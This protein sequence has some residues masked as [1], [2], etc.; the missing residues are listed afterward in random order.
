M[1]WSLATVPRDP[2]P[3]QT[4]MISRMRQVRQSEGTIYPEIHPPGTKVLMRV[5]GGDL[6]SF[7][8]AVVYLSS[9]FVVGSVAWVPMAYAWLYRKWQRTPKEQRRKRMIYGALLLLLPAIAVI[10]PH[11]THKLGDRL[12][13]RKWFIWKSWLRFVAMEIVTD[14]QNFKLDFHRDQIIT[15]VIPHGLFPFSLGLVALPELP[16]RLFGYFR[17]IVATA[18]AIVPFLETILSWL[19]AVYV[20][21]RS[22]AAYCIYLSILIA[23]FIQRCFEVSC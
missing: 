6:T 7:D 4:N 11:R 16:S 1:T 3:A 20:L 8:R 15:A 10:G 18:T 23:S 17:P 21:F 22:A 9:L 12:G 5:P 19:R 14:V 13:L 2:A